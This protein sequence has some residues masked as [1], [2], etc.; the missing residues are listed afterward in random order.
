MGE[1]K[2]AEVDPPTAE[3]FVNEGIEVA[4]D[5]DWC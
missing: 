4:P 5:E 1:R 3:A 2:K